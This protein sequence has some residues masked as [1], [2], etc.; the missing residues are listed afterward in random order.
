MRSHEIPAPKNREM[1]WGDLSII[2]AIGRTGSL[3]GAARSLGKTHSTIF[4]N[5]RAIEEKTGVRFFDKFD[6]GY[7][8]TDAGRTAIEYAERIEGEVHALG[9]E[10]LGRDTKLSGRIRITCPD[11]FAADHAPGLVAA[12]VAQN[13][14]ISVD[15]SPAHGAFDLNRREA[16]IAIRATGAP[17]ESAY[18]RKICPF[19]FALYGHPDVVASIG[20]GVLSD[21]PFCAI[22]GSLGLFYKLFWKTKE[23]GE[24]HMV[25]QCVSTRA[26]LNAAAQGLGL[27]FLP[28]YVGDADDRL[29]RISDPLQQLELNLWI[30]THPDLRNTARVRAFMSFLY[31]ELAAKADLWGG[32]SRATSAHNFLPRPDWSEKTRSQA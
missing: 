32:H 20:A 24:E 18:G 17:P 9:L 12:F 22:E 15:V 27:T 23:Q 19:R 4:R 25:F 11:S 10:I 31:D 1:E 3:S 13:P 16:E 29:I 7:M 28:C 2:L 21:Q 26:V 8:P 5:I 14:D 6:N 30:L